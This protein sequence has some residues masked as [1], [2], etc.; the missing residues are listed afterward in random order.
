VTYAGRPFDVDAVTISALKMI[1]AHRDRP[2]PTRREV[3]GWTG[4]PRRRVWRFLAELQERGLI[5]IE[6]RGTGTDN[7]WR[8]M[9]VIGGTWTG[10]TARRVPKRE[11]PRLLEM[12]REMA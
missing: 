5:E 12:M 4:I 10:W 1:E 8:R 7:V 11:R 6:A 9:R 3:Q 2:C